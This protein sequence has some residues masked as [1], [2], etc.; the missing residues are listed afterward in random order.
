[1]EV[2]ETYQTQPHFILPTSGYEQQIGLL[3]AMM[4]YTRIGTI[5]LISNLQV[6]HLDYV[7]D[8]QSNSMG[9]LLLHVAAIEAS[10]QAW[11]FEDRG[12]N[13]QE[14]S[15]WEAAFSLGYKAR[16][17]IRGFTAEEYLNVLFQVRQRTLEELKE[18]DDL[19]LYKDIPGKSVNQYQ[20]WFHVIEDEIN[21][22]GQIKWLIARA[23]RNVA[24]DFQSKFT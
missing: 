7:H 18:R 15:R 4:E 16:S 11:S 8:E 23:V 22:R 1:M 10:Q 21:H 12:W 13:K 6:E 2:K 5:E 24:C 14:R 19:W 17:E 9:A 20:R 3:V